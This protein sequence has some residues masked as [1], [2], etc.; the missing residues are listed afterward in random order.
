M[1]RGRLEAFSDGV[2]AVIITIMVLELHPPEGSGWHDLHSL[3]PKLAVYVLSFVFV[4]IYW[5]NHHHLMQVVDRVNGTV[6][7]ANLHLLFW[8]S[9]TPAA[10][11]WLGPHIADSTPVG[12]Y[13]AVLLGSAIAY[14]IL[15]RALIGADVPES[16]V[17]QAIGDDWKGKLSIVAYIAGIA[18]SPVV[19]W[20]SVALYIG[21]AVAWFVPDR[22]MERFVT[23]EPSE[24]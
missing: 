9:L 1:S 15:V 12:V 2:I 6:L 11:S 10:A 7:W 5:N 22:R 20:L 23:E 19:P 3:W 17:A 8:L 18:L 16:R 21:V 13:G 14:T 4:G 24:V